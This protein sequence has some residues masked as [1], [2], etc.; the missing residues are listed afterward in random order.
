MMLVT[1]NAPADAGS[2]HGPALPF[3]AG[4]ERSSGLESARWVVPPLDGVRSEPGL[5]ARCLAALSA[6]LFRHS[7]QESFR[8][9][10][11]DA[12]AEGWTSRAVEVGV[13]ADQTACELES[14]LATALARAGRMP[15]TQSTELPSVAL[16]VVTAGGAWETWPTPTGGFAKDLHV[17]CV[18]SPQGITYVADFEASRLSARAAQHICLQHRTLLRAFEQ[19]PNESIARL[20]LLDPEGR[21]ELLAETR[22]PTAP[23]APLVAAEFERRAAEHPDAVALSIG[24]Q[25]L[26]YGELNRRV[27]QLARFLRNRGIG[28]GKAVAVCMEPSFDF[29][30]AMLGIFKAGGIHVPLDPTHPPER[31]KVFLEDV[32]PIVTLSRSTWRAA[33]DGVLPAVVY[34]DELGAE[35]GALASDNPGY[36]VAADDVTYVVYT[37]GTTGKPKGV[38]VTYGNLAHEV[39]VARRAYGYGA[40]DVVPAIARFTFSITFF[41]LLCPLAAGSEL[42]LL[43]RS[44]VLDMPWMIAMLQRVTCVHIAPSL[45]R[46]FFAYI[47]EH[48]VP[49]SSFARVRHVSSGGDMV[50][51]DVLEGFKRVL[52]NAEVFVIYGCSEMVCMG[53]AYQAPRDR[54][55]RSTRVGRPFPNVFIRLL[56]PAGQPV[57]PGVVGEVCFGG[58]GVAKGYLN[59]PETTALKFVDF[60]GERIYRTGDLGRIDEDGDVEL[61]GRADF[62]IQLR[63]IRIEPAEVE[64]NL[65]MMPDVRDAIV[66]APVLPD[67]EKRLVAYVVPETGRP[68]TSRV[69]REYLMARL[70]EY[71][72]PASFVILEAMPVNANGKVD[73]LALA[74]PVGD[75]LAPQ[76][77]ARPAVS[78]EEQRMAQLWDGVLGVR[79]I[80]LDD[81]FFDAGG[82]SLRAVSLVAAIER[83]FGAALPVSALLANPTVAGVLEA[84]SGEALAKGSD[85]LV[86]LR[87]GDDSKPPIFFIH[88]GDG[89]T[90]PYRNLALRLDAGHSVYG[91]APKRDRLHP[92]LHTRLGEMVDDYVRRIRQT[93]PHGPY[94]VGG[95][96]IGGF[97]AFEVTRR[98]AGDGEVVGPVLLFDAVHVTAERR[99]AARERLDRLSGSLE[100]S[101]GQPLWSRAGR[102]VRKVTRGAANTV[103]FELKTGMTRRMNGVRLR[104]SRYFLDHGRLPPAIISHV[105]VNATL[106]FA[107]KEYVVP[108][109]YPG[110]V[111]LFRA[112]VVDPELNKLL[113]DRPHS[114]LF[115]EPE[116]GW[117]DR[118]RSLLVIDVPAGHSSMLREPAVARLS[119]V[120]QEHIDGAITAITASPS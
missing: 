94:L 34:V 77:G 118:V 64:A 44:H 25:R 75:L 114:H 33:A 74:K 43:E 99:Q 5:Q 51:P 78:G 119:Q 101:K 58:A 52:S 46:K 76:L 112:T 8:I 12:A 15:I 40:A 10:F 107:E 6:L 65:R 69:L 120:V 117:R 116:L 71:M 57:P 21:Q 61:I 45:W 63:G 67:G 91:V 93:Q 11:I 18:V 82:D 86:C 27:N 14:N 19:T 66:A 48:R 85:A 35:L 38:L 53:L 88:D 59:A 68:L 55:I 42:W 87:R 60:E 26:S 32:Q 100:S 84:I 49:Y 31:W 73:R 95:L 54:T 2:L 106:R 13:D 80:G 9:V 39:D 56:D 62:Q 20:T 24:D 110:Q 16:S 7:Q 83:E 30:V 92:I 90:I 28:A 41:E 3:P 98:L 72:V 104:I 89:E 111:L 108:P 37:S 17:R 70:P 22:G 36:E 96:C 115:K 109:V 113:D 47:E 4:C 105:G 97:I 102:L 103:A 23:P 81:D 29:M 1:P 50:P 79:G